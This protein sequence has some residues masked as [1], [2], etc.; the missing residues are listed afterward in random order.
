VLYTKGQGGEFFFFSPPLARST[1]RRERQH[2]GHGGELGGAECT[3]RSEVDLEEM[4]T[5]K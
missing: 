3:G 1:L 2:S 4:W 5:Q